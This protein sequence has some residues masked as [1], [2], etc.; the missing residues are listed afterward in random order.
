MRNCL[1]ME[2]FIREPVPPARMRKPTLAKPGKGG[3]SL[4]VGDWCREEVDR[5]V[6][7]V[8]GMRRAAGWN[9]WERGEAPRTSSRSVANE[10]MVELRRLK[11][12]A[13]L[14]ST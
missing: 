8:D 14:I 2:A 10:I 7:C 5:E 9:A 3:G 11:E 13:H 6:E 4:L 12:F 1:G